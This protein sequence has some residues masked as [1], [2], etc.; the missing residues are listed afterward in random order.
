L[1]LSFLL[2]ISVFPFRKKWERGLVFFFVSLLLAVSIIDFLSY[3]LIENI[4][5]FI[6]FQYLRIL[7]ILILGGCALHFCLIFADRD[8]FKGGLYKYLPYLF[9]ILV[10]IAFVNLQVDVSAVQ[11]LPALVIMNFIFNQWLVVLFLFIALILSF[12]LLMRIFTSVPERAGQAEFLMFGL[13]APILFAIANEIIFLFYRFPSVPFY[14]VSVFS[15]FMLLY[16]V[17]RHGLGKG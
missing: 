13:L 1:A 9:A 15:M 16:A 12:G 7:L 11:G 14:F 5:F 6:S 17:K 10:F 2:V 3:R 4:F 8:T